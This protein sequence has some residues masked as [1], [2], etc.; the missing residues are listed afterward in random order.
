MYYV[1]I[2]FIIQEREREKTNVT[3]KLIIF[4]NIVI[5]NNNVNTITI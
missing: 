1:D 3:T 5:N 2:H 4:L